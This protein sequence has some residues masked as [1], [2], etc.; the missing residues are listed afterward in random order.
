MLRLRLSMVHPKCGGMQ[1]MQVRCFILIMEYTA[2]LSVMRSV[3]VAL[4]LY[5]HDMTR[6]PICL[7]DLP[8]AP[9]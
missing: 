9:M 5:L 8:I 4:H 6:I 7:T 2:P 3:L 1:A